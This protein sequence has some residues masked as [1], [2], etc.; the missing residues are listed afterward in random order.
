MAG[1]LQ[2]HKAHQCRDARDD[3]PALYEHMD[4]LRHPPEDKLLAPDT[5]FTICA[6][7]SNDIKFVRN[8]QH[9]VFPKIHSLAMTSME[10]FKKS[11]DVYAVNRFLAQGFHKPLDYVTLACESRTDIGKFNIGLRHVLSLARQQVLIRGFEIDSLNLKDIFEACSDVHMLVLYDCAIT[12]VEALELNPCIEYNISVLDLFETC[13]K[14][15]QDKLGSGKIVKFSEALAKTS[16]KDT[17]KRIHAKNSEFESKDLEHVLS[18]C[19]LRAS[20]CGAEKWPYE[21]SHNHETDDIA[22]DI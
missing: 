7:S 12:D 3:T 15:D 4:L 5:V 19:G 17:L 11:K 18:T 22:P 10:S 1:K 14:T 6:S 2:A 21:K 13:V 9:L 16:L 20:V 8:T